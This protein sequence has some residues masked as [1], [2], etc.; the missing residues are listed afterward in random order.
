MCLGFFF[1]LQKVTF[2]CYLISDGD[3]TFVV[4]NYVD[5][6]LQPKKNRKISVGYRYNDI[7]VQ[8]SFSNKDGVFRMTVM[9]GNRGI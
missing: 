6:N 1:F 4:Y 9:P 8:N 7:I 5:V 3:N 2:Q